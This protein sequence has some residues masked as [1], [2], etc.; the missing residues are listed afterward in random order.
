[1]GSCGYQQK[2]EGCP[3]R[4][5]EQAAEDNAGDTH[6]QGEQQRMA[7]TAMA[8]IMTV[9]KTEAKCQ[10]IQIRQHGAN[11]ADGQQ[12]PGN[13]LPAATESD[14]QGNGGVG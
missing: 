7:E 11:H 2:P 13:D 5:F 1:M 10:Y 12:R 6:E 14:S 9:G 3:R 4:R 8:E